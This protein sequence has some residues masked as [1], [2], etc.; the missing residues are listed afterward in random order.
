MPP[1]DGVIHDIGY[2]RYSGPRL[3]RGYALRSLYVHGVRTAYGF[4][5]SA[6]AKIFPWAIAGIMVLVATIDVAIRARSGI[7]PI[8]YLDYPANLA[9]PVLFF[10]AATAPELVSRDLRNKVLPLY[11]SRPLRRSDYAWAK[12]AALIT[13]IFALIAVPMGLIYVCGLFTV[14][15]WP[16]MRHETWNFLGGLGLA[17]IYAIVFGALGL[18][19]ASLFGRRMV[20]VVW[21]PRGPT[22]HI[23]SFGKA[24]DREKAKYKDGMG[25]P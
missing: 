17:G 20:L 8:T 21:T 14:S 22:R 15:G 23:I 25:G 2:Q 19:I 10:V 24:N 11:F 18:V 4:G 16:A 5:R 6:K 1:V 3:G 9:V 13:A 12:L 7:M